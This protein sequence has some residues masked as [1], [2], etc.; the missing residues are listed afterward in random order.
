MH[1]TTPRMNPR[2]T[3]DRAPEDRPVIDE[4]PIFEMMV[5]ALVTA[6]ERT[7]REAEFAEDQL[8][9]VPG[10]EP[11]SH[12]LALAMHLLHTIEEQGLLLARRM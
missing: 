2:T 9:V 12:T 11:T 7:C 6:T 5:E 8:V 1:T 4:Q 10:G 3:S